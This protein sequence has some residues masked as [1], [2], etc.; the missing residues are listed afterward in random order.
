ME[1]WHNL[2]GLI[3]EQTN[4]DD[5]LVEVSIEFMH[6]PVEHRM[7]YCTY[8]MYEALYKDLKINFVCSNYSF[9]KYVFRSSD[10]T[11]QVKEKIVASVLN[12]VK[13]EHCLFEMAEEF[14]EQDGLLQSNLL[15]ELE[16]FQKASLDMEPFLKAS[17][18]AIH[19]PA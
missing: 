18:N 4:L 5:D 7:M 17:W 1:T 3:I 11:N 12:A 19:L 15:N 14:L 8:A 13:N 6:T 10:L 16:R 2:N 9:T